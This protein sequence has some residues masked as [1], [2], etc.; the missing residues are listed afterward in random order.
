MGRRA[1]GRRPTAAIV[2]MAGLLALA[3]LAG[4]GGSRGPG[5]ALDG[6]AWRLSAWS[7]TGLTAGDFTITARFAGGRIEGDSGVNAYGGPYTTGPGSAFSVGRLA[8]TAM[9]G[10]G[11]RMRAEQTYLALLGKARSF[12]RG[13]GRL[14]LFG[15]QGQRLLLFR[16]TGS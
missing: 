1:P 5:H 6:T 9:G 10:S 4:C 11:P 15:A 8:M 16:E 7:A 12:A 13:G 2:V 3:G 14:T